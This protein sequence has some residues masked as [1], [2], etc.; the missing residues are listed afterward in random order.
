MSGHARLSPT[1]IAVSPLCAA[2]IQAIDQEQF[3]HVGVEPS[4]VPILAL[5]ST[6]HF[7]AD[8]QPIAETVLCVV[9]P[10]AHVSDPERLPYRNLRKGIRLNPLGPARV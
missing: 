1:R 10:G 2:R 3:R 8:F 6:V 7:R 4:D 5:K 9:S